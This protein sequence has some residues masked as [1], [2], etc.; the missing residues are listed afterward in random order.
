MRKLSKKISM[1]MVLAMLVSLFSGIVSASAASAWSF[2]S[3]KYDVEVGETIEMEKNEYADFDLFKNDAAPEGYTVKWSSSDSD[4]VWVNAKTGQLRAD[5]FKTADYGD[6]ATISATFTNTATGKSAT[7]SFVIV[8]AEAADYEIAVNFGDEVLAVGQKYDLKAVVKADGQEVEAKVEFA[9]DGKAIDAAYTPAAAGEFTI[10]TT[11]TIDGK[12]VAEAKTAVVV[13]EAGLESAKQTAYNAVALTFGSADV[14][15]AV[16]ADASKLAS[17]YFIGENEIQAFV[18][19]VKVD[20]KNPA[21]VNVTLYN[22]LTKGVTYKFTYG[23]KSATVVGADLTQYASMTIAT[24]AVPG[25]SLETVKVNLYNADGILVK[26][27]DAGFSLEAVLDGAYSITGNQ[28]YFHNKYV[29]ATAT[30]KATYWM[31][32]DENGNKIADLTATGTIT[33]YNKD[34]TSISN[35]NEW[36]TEGTAD[37][38]WGGNTAKLAIGETKQLYFRLSQFDREGNWKANLVFD[39]TSNQLEGGTLRFVT[40][41]QDVVLVDSNTGVFHPVGVGSA[42]I[43]VYR[44]F[45]GDF[46]GTKQAMGV[47]N[48][49]VVAYRVLTSVAPS[50]TNTKLSLDVAESYAL[51]C[52]NAKDQLGA[53]MGGADYFLKLENNPTNVKVYVVTANGDT[54][55]VYAPGVDGASF[56][57]SAGTAESGYADFFKIYAEAIDATQWYTPSVQIGLTV[58]HANDYKSFYKVVPVN[59]A[60]PNSNSVRY[61]LD[62]VKG[63]IDMNLYADRWNGDM[64][65]FETEIK[66]N[67]YD[68]N[69]YL[70]DVIDDELAYGAAT[71]GN[72]FWVVKKNGQD[73]RND[74]DVANRKFAPITQTAG[75][76]GNEVTK[77]LQPATYTVEIYK[78]NNGRNQFVISKNIVLTDS[79]PKITF[80]K[81]SNK[82]TTL[83]QGTLTGLLKNNNLKFM[84][85]GELITNDDWVWL[86][87]IDANV[88][89]NTNRINVK[90]VSIGQPFGVGN[91]V[92]EVPVYTTFELAQ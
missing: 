34:A 15:K 27:T 57:I 76:Y 6:K 56:A 83:D 77:D 5:K 72:Y 75:Q 54:E 40:S 79:T 58:K 44:Y 16:A 80:V 26:T 68:T 50:L 45:N 39:G 14:A 10:V 21:V 38:Q 59:V 2:K 25:E 88:I 22:D 32:Y 23:N 17:V 49:N 86:T 60:V 36:S 20:E 7:R 1:L 51:L 55:L 82:V 12:V 71:T 63:S 92:T 43:I 85:G 89:V 67:I 46:D 37:Y 35:I 29:A 41:N 28:I 81:V 90:T 84:V 91:W 73:A 74:F 65:R 8:V 61:S 4:A 13:V 69:G 52:P 30:V 87:N 78:N 70:V 47:F 9:I 42:Q 66:M 48:V 19:T 3:S 33:S 62:S 31:P 11:A 24:T 18:N 53:A 64:S